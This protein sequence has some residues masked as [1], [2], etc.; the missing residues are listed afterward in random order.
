MPRQVTDR[1]RLIFDSFLEPLSAGIRSSQ[2]TDRKLL[3]ES[4][5]IMADLSIE[6]RRDS[7]C[8][9]LVGQIVDPAH[10]E[11]QLE[12]APVVLQGPSGLIGV[13]ATNQFGEFHFDF[14]AEAGVAVEIGIT[15]TRW[16]LIELPDRKGTLLKTTEG[17]DFQLES[18][19]IQVT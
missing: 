12:R 18:R 16:M 17:S 3:Y 10:S 1:V 13:T 15:E 19:E 6:P 2:T 8:I 14:D 7:E 9:T 4:D 11:R 5:G